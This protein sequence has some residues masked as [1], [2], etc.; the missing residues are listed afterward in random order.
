[1]SDNQEK[2]TEESTINDFFE[3][4]DMEGGG[5]RVVPATIKEDR[6]DTRL[7]LAVRGDLETASIIFAAVWETIQN[8]SDVAKQREAA[9]DDDPG[10]IVS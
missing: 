5:V 4:F 8:L 7:M 3:A 1:M 6:D 2:L 10:I 9:E